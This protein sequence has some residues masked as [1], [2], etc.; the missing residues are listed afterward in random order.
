MERNLYAGHRASV[1]ESLPVGI[2]ISS[3]FDGFN[4]GISIFHQTI[5]HFYIG[6]N[7][8]TCILIDFIAPLNDDEGIQISVCQLSRVFANSFISGTPGSKSGLP[9]FAT[10]SG[11][12]KIIQFTRRA[13]IA[14]LFQKIIFICLDFRIR[15]I[16]I[17]RLHDTHENLIHLTS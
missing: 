4:N 13:C 2:P 8:L 11:L 14:K 12:L 3:F 9:S 6:H 10:E 17:N 5:I 16:F 1:T 7:H 15:Q